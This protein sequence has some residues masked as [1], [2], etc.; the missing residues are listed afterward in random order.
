[1]YEIVAFEQQRLTCELGERIGK[2][3]A[4]IQLGRMAA[5]FAEIAIARLA[6]LRRNGL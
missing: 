6:A 3:I 2:A 4:E 5:A 1:V